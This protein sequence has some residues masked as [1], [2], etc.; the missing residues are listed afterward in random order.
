[1]QAGRQSYRI[2]RGA[3]R[4]GTAWALQ[5]LAAARVENVDLQ[6][7]RGTDW[8]DA[9]EPCGRRGVT[10]TTVGAARRAAAAPPRQKS[11]SVSSAPAVPARTCAACVN[12]ANP[13]GTTPPMRL[14]PIRPIA[15]L[16]RHPPATTIA[17]E[18]PRCRARAVHVDVREMS[19]S[20][21]LREGSRPGRSSTLYQANL[22]RGVDPATGGPRRTHRRTSI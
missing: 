21:T 16:I 13:V 4:A 2:Q 3:S 5:F 22:T 19:T 12:P 1:M 17:I 15:T 6:I 20:V 14:S 8:D 11:N 9:M 18:M 7:L 10:R